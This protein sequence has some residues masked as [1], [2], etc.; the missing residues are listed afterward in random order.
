MKEAEQQETHST[1]HTWLPVTLGTWLETIVVEA[2][3]SALKGQE[4][5]RRQAVFHKDK[6]C[7]Q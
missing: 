3:P 5:M 2:M 7:G 4:T 1:K 6:L